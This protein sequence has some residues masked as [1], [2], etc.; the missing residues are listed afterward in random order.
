MAYSLYKITGT[1]TTVQVVMIDFAYT[2]IQTTGI[3]SINQ[4][5]SRCDIDGLSL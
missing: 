5:V 1:T 2:T 3:Q 4:S